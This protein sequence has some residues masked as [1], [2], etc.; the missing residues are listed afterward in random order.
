MVM[1]FLSP[2]DERIGLDVIE[3]PT[4]RRAV[5]IDTT[6]NN[7]IAAFRSSLNS[8]E[9]VELRTYEDDAPL[10]ESSIEEPKRRAHPALLLAIFRVGNKDVLHRAT[11]QDPAEQQLA[12]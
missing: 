11:F 9:V 10:F 3:R 7:T 2:P 1:T 4:Y 6:K 5:D 8:D 12:L